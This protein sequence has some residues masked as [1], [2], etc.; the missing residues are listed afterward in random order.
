MSRNTL[1]AI[2]LGCV[3]I[4]ASITF[5]FIMHQ[6]GY[7]EGAHDAKMLNTIE[8]A[9]HPDGTHYH[10]GKE[11]QYEGLECPIIQGIQLRDYQ[12]ELSADSIK[13]YDGQRFVGTTGFE[14]HCSLNCLMLEDNQ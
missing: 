7:I 12:I 9:V 5:G 4:A 6:A 3:F 8:Q 14:E 10:D 2:L 11:C 13:L 1:I